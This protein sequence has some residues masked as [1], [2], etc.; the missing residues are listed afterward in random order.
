ML[1]DEVIN[2]NISERAKN[3]MASSAF[4]L[5]RK[6]NFSLF[7]HLQYLALP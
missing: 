7:S 5:A 2:A 1:S 6:L 4:E 3:A